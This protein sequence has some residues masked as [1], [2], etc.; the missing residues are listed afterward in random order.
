[1]DHD[2]IDPDAPAG[3]G[4][5]GFF[6][7]ARAPGPKGVHKQT[8]ISLVIFPGEKTVHHSEGGAHD[9]AMGHIYVR[10]GHGESY[11]IAGGPPRQGPKGPGGHSAGPTPAGHYILGS[12]EHHTTLGWPASSVPFG[13]RLRLG[14]DGEV[15][16]LDGTWK[17]ATG[18]L[19]ETT[20]AVRTWY[21]NSKKHVPAPSAIN[22]EARAYFF[23][24]RGKLFDE[25]KLN[26][27]G[28]WSWNLRLPNR[29]RTSY[30]IHTTPENESATDGAATEAAKAMVLL[31]QSHGC[32]H[33]RPKD[34]DKMVHKGYLKAGIEVEVRPYGT[35]G[36]PR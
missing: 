26:D 22:L 4:G 18:P 24:S 21:Q 28:R 9:V 19:G 7:V 2:H 34:R 32:V 16:F 8:R 17:K 25:W 27:F 1:M 5:P 30:Y 20:K 6:H 11:E 35:K 12:R 29:Q 23:D 3:G 14:A 15:E 36:P 13:A 31:E 10:G 33:I